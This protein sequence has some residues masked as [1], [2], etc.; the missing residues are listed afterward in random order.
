MSKD[1]ILQKLWTI[2]CYDKE[3]YVKE[4]WKEL[5]R[6][7]WSGIKAQEDLVTAEHQRDQYDARRRESITKYEKL[8]KSHNKLKKGIRE[9]ITSYLGMTISHSHLFVPLLDKLENLLK[10][11]E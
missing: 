9:L 10:E 3:A 5:E 8:R 2:A 1:A 11:K 6:L 7:L 4:D